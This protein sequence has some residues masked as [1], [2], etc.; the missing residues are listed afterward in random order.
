M[1][2]QEEGIAVQ[3]FAKSDAARELVHP[4]EPTPQEDQATLLTPNAQS[5]PWLGNTAVLQVRLVAID[6]VAVFARLGHRARD[7]HH[8]VHILRL[9]GFESG[10]SCCSQSLGELSE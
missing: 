6:R 7:L 9:C 2:R 4:L 3:R 8:V 5:A 10:L 1:C